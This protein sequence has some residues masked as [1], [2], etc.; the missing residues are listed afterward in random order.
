MN[1]YLPYVTIS[2]KSEIIFAFY[3]TSNY[4]NLYNNQNVKNYTSRFNLVRT[5]Y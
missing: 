5:I 4:N 3:C 1:V 2:E